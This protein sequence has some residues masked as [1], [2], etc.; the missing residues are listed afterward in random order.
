MIK[1]SDIFRKPAV[2]CIFPMT[3]IHS[4]IHHPLQ[5]CL[6]K[7]PKE[8]PGPPQLKITMHSERLFVC[9]TGC[10]SRQQWNKLGADYNRIMHFK[11]NVRRR[12]G[13]NISGRSL[14]SAKSPQ[15][16]LSRNLANFSRCYCIA[17]LRL[18]KLYKGRGILN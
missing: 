6:Y 17:E 16:V 12:D 5:M 14:H 9:V 18:K 10:L 8:Q 1:N 3:H 11:E 13:N 4:T 2:T 7:K 15:S